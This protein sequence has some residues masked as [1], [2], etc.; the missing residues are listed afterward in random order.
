MKKLLAVALCST[1]LIGAPV[2][3]AQASGADGGG[4]GSSPA[5][6]SSNSPPLTPSQ[7]ETSEGAI[8]NPPPLDRSGNAEHVSEKEGNTGDGNGDSAAS[9]GGGND[10]AD[11]TGGGDGSGAG[12]AAGS[13][14]AAG[15]ATGGASGSGN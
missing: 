2:V 8:V 5:P 10:G 9:N 3:Y 4:T 6:H 13:G 1:A 15:G 7:T 12:G 14:D 11:S